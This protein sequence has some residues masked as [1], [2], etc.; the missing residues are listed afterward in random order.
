M[1]SLYQDN[2]NPTPI[3]R[4]RITS[5]DGGGDVRGNSPRPESWNV[6]GN[7]IDTYKQPEKE[8]PLS[9]FERFQN[10]L[11]QL[12]FYA[13]PIIN[14]SKQV[15]QDARMRNQIRNINQQKPIW[16]YN[17]QYGDNQPIIK[18]ANGAQVRTGSDESA[19]FRI[20]N[21]ELIML[22]DG[23][24]EKA[25]G[26][27]KK[28]DDIATILPEGTKIFSNTLK[29][30]NSKHT[31]AKLA[32]KHDY[33]EE[34]KKLENPY[35][36]LVSRTTAERMLQ[37]KQKSLDSLFKE[38]QALN[39]DSSGEMSN[40]YGGVIMNEDG[41]F[42]YGGELKTGRQPI[43]VAIPYSQNPY[44]E[45]TNDATVMRSFPRPLVEG[46]EHGGMSYASGGPVAPINWPKATATDSLNVYNS[47]IKTLDYYDKNKDYE[48][49][50]TLNSYNPE[51]NYFKTG[52]LLK[53]LAENV[54]EY[55]KE[56]HSDIKGNKV[57][58][59]K[60]YKNIS[61]TQFQQR[62]L[63][64]GYLDI[65]SPMPLYDR[66]IVPNQISTY[67]NKHMGDRV[68]VPMYDPISVKP[69][70][71]LTEEEKKLREER[72]GSSTDSGVVRQTPSPLNPN[73]PKQRTTGIPFLAPET[74][75][76]TPTTPTN[77]NVGRPQQV[78]YSYEG[79]N[80]INM[81]GKYYTQAEFDKYFSENKNNL[82]IMPK[83]NSVG[84]V[85]VPGKGIVDYRNYNASMLGYKDG[86]IT[87][88]PAGQ[89]TAYRAWIDK[90][91]YKGSKGWAMDDDTYSGHDY[92]MRGYWKE[93]QMSP[94]RDKMLS[95]EEG[96]HFPD[97]YK[98]PSHESHSDESKYRKPPF[99][100]KG[101]WEGENFI[102]YATGGTA[103]P[104]PIYTSN[105]NDP[106]LRSYNDSLKLY[107]HFNEQHNKSRI[108]GKKLVEDYNNSIPWYDL[109]T[110]KAKYFEKANDSGEDFMFNYGDE[111]NHRRNNWADPTIKG[112]VNKPTSMFSNNVW[113]A[114]PNFKKPVQPIE[115]RA[116]ID[117]PKPA[118]KPKPKPSKTS[119]IDKGKSM[120][121]AGKETAYWNSKLVET[122]PIYVTDKNDPR[123]TE[124]NDRLNTYNN[125]AI[126]NKLAKE[127]IAKATSSDDA[128]AR[129]EKLRE[130]YPMNDSYTTNSG[131]PKVL[132][133][134]NWTD[135]N[136]IWYEDRFAAPT[137]QVL[138]QEPPVVRKTPSPLNPNAP[139]QRTTG[140]PFLAPETTK[141]D[142]F[143]TEIKDSEW[144][145]NGKPLVQKKF[146][147]TPK[148][149]AKT[150][151]SSSSDKPMAN[152]VRNAQTGWDTPMVR[153][154]FPD[155]TQQLVSPADYDKWAKQNPNHE[156]HFEM[157][158]EVMYEDDN[159]RA[160]KDGG[161]HIN[162]KNKGK[163]TSWAKSH[164]MGVQEAASHV[165]A[166][167]GN[168]SSAT[169]KRANFAK[170]AAK[171]HHEDGG[172]IHY[173]QE[174]MKGGTVY[175]RN[176][177]YTEG[178][179]HDIDE[180][181]INRLRSLGYKIK[182]IK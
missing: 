48:K 32:S 16:D 103:G 75:A 40:A 171:W 96:Q 22:P 128:D 105:R 181:E 172:Y 67:A 109:L 35:T 134:R 112:L 85:Y 86:G 77:P 132:A 28:T 19:Q 141:Q 15:D 104:K 98:L 82:R 37:R 72:Y 90:Q 115:Y 24:L 153:I 126:F 46:F 101:F 107:N 139:Q 80:Q 88:L 68:T 152:I 145:D 87:S 47:A 21:G 143:L 73:A 177:A 51:D 158:G 64:D 140:V 170:N 7:T 133:K 76:S 124:Y 113:G 162:P 142:T 121:T 52:N 84:K 58:L 14:Y 148:P 108:E 69:Y 45:S 178:S 49:W 116:D 42:A 18:A 34:L 167:K 117:K 155:G 150:T 41:Q 29:P 23:K 151:T 60:Y 9:V 97:T 120:T 168:Y 81:G 149:V 129:L 38:Q 53:D 44:Y 56:S 174:F 154:K 146:T 114:S 161:I 61:P 20:D 136:S 102:E 106:R 62:E 173:D 17:E 43:P 12:P 122:T 33:S 165:M 118:D 123:L 30:V 13:D 131:K 91:G 10:G 4:K 110:P 8:Q 179:E 182:I 164:G 5:Y 92:D 31:F 137:N 1:I 26:S 50:N 159:F 79:E 135:R 70:N 138:Y 57:P 125:S 176:G 130:L 175:S 63:A 83:A 95:M 2:D 93:A 66:R 71:M 89:E 99:N 127:E 160:F 74:P 54:K 144:Y 156:K 25:Q 100:A 36:S 119:I 111:T 6:D 163:F 169:V 147:V 59:S 180:E 78:N 55:N 3:R 27:S 39:G 11:K 166:N 65:N 157:G 94:N